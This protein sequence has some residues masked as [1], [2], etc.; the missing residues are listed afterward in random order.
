MVK[1]FQRIKRL[2]QIEKDYE[3]L[4]ITTDSLQRIAREQHSEIQKLHK[5]NATLRMLLDEA[6]RVKRY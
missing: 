1:M 6:S 5:E 3:T 4:K 2:F